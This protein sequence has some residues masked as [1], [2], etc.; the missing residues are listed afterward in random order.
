MKLNSVDKKNSRI[1]FLTHNYIR[2]RGDF[3]GVFLHLLATKLTELGFEIFVV[4][5]HDAGLPEY[6]E[7]DRIKICRFRYADDKDE[8]FAYRGNMHQQVLTNP[9]KIFR[10]IKF[11]KAAYK[12]TVEIIEKENIGTVS[13]HWVIPNGIIGY[14]LK[15]KFGDKIKMFLHSHGTDVRLLTSYYLIYLFFKPVIN[16]FERW[17]VVSNYLKR[18]ILERDIYIAD[19]I[20]VIPLPNDEKLFFPDENISEDPNLILSVSRLTVQKRI[21]VF[22]KALA[23]LKD[24]FPELRAEIYGDGPEK[25]KLQSLIDQKQLSEKVNILPPVSQNQLRDV[26]NK[27]A[28]VVLNSVDEGFG[29]SLTEAMLCR[30]PVIGTDSGGITDIIDENQTGLFVEADNPIELAEAIKKLVSD[31]VLR[32]NLRLAGYQKAME[33]FSSQSTAKRY[34]DLFRKSDKS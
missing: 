6:E 8:T 17:T 13:V 19:K 9:F 32:N 27:A 34:A 33:N 31:T 26:Y 3:A 1:L 30:R 20:D 4:A 25:Q 16:K 22:I 5:P 23:I 21:D 15:D 14:F 7:I 18:L 29:L 12:K 2:G 28:I 10:L 11:L 24:E